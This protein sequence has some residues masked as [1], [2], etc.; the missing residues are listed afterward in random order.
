MH[1]SLYSR[2]RRSPQQQLELLG[3]SLSVTV[4]THLLRFLLAES[5]APPAALAEA[6]AG[7]AE[8]AST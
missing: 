8:A 1:V 5:A 3:N 6:E 7:A 2:P 4:V